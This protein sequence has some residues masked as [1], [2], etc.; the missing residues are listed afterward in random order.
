[1]FDNNRE[2]LSKSLVTCSKIQDRSTSLLSTLAVSLLTSFSSYE[3]VTSS[4]RATHSRALLKITSLASAGL[5]GDSEEAPELLAQLLS[6][7]TVLYSKDSL[8]A[9][10]NSTTLY[11]V[12]LAVR[13]E[14]LNFCM[15]HFSSSI[16]I[17]S[18]LISAHRSAAL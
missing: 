17:T 13:N 9:P 1:M 7:F 10:S 6:A 4:A 18:H 8:D 3:V 15:S 12:N 11:P 5:V 14:Q 16:L 2:T